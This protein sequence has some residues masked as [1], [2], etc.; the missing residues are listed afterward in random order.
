M[1]KQLYSAHEIQKLLPILEKI[2]DSWS[3]NARKMTAGFMM[4]FTAK[5]AYVLGEDDHIRECSKVTLL[6]LLFDKHITVRLFAQ[7]AMF[8]FWQLVLSGKTNE[9]SNLIGQFKKI[10]SQKSPILKTNKKHGAI[11]GLC[12]IVEATPDSVPDYL[13]SLLLYLRGWI[14]EPQPVSV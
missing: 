11:L 2:S 14:A 4:S 12:A 9:K 13:P 10:L 3:M 8:Y 6:K 1:A 5:N 7:K